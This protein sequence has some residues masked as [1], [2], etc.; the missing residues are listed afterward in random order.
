MDFGR[1]ITAM[2]TPFSADG[3]IDWET[4]GRL[5]DYLIEDQLSDGVVVCGTTGESPTVNDEEKQALF[6]FAVKHARGRCKIIAGTGSNDTAH[7]IHVTRIAEQCGVDAVLLVAPYYNK[8]TQEGLYQHFKAIAESTSLPVMLYNVPGRTI[9]SLSAATT[10]R[11]A[12]LPNVV[13][14]KECAALDQVAEI[15]MGAPEG[16]LVYSGDDSSALPALAVG[17]HGV[18]SVASHIIGK[19]MKAMIQA[20]L[21]GDVSRAAKLHG[22]QLPIFKGLFD[23]PNP[24]LVKAAL[25]LQGLPVGGVRLPLVAASESELE[26]LRRVLKQEA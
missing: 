18:V 14:T 12:Q 16:F 23:L 20:Y 5:L 10:L 25:S 19:P 6:A 8:P 7:S 17:A 22:E 11:L 4:T 3:S 26:T 9:V 24:V 1:L 15:V 21:D 13:A 2:V